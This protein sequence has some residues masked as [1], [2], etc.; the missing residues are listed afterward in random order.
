MFEKVMQQMSEHHP[1]WRTQGTN[2]Q[3]KCFEKTMWNNGNIFHAT[4]P[5]AIL[6]KGRGRGYDGTKS[7][8]GGTK[9]G[10]PGGTLT[11]ISPGAI[12]R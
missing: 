12:G 1:E 8:N 11:A 2:I 6:Q 3:K 7:D 10:T 9:W 5:G 4:G